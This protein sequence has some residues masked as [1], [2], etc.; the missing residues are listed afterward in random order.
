MIP[1]TDLTSES[2]EE[3]LQRLENKIINLVN[4]YKESERQRLQLAEEVADL[5]AAIHNMQES[6]RQAEILKGKLADLL[7]SDDLTTEELKKRL[8][9][10][11]EKIDR[12]LLFLN[13]QLPKSA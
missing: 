3:I 9:Q 5:R 2:P 8:D 11:I 1:A 10:Y 7:T 6:S 12:V 13:N 4:A